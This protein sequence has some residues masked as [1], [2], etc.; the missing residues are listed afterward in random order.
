RRQLLRLIGGLAAAGVT[1]TVAGCTDEPEG[2]AMEQPS[3][4]TIVIGFI[5]PAVGAY[6]GIGDEITKGMKLYLTESNNL[7]GTH[8]VD[9][10]IAEEGANADSA[11]AAV[12]SLIKQ[13]VLAIGGVAN[14]A[15]LGVVADAADKARIP[16]IGTTA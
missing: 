5:A 1:A 15:V 4:R 9:I 12:E 13:G 6:G 3:G 7:V 14:P 8:R 11:A 2:N 16:L 10:R